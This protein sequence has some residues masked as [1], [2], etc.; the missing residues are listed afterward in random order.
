MSL[1][2]SNHAE[3]EPFCI[4]CDCFVPYNDMTVTFTF[5]QSKIKHHFQQ[6]NPPR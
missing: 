3:A 2:R 4:A 1:E 6:N 5:I